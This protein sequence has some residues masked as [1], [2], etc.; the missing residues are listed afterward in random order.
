M[1][2][3]RQY[4]L[5]TLF[6]VREQAKISAEEIFVAAQNEV[7]TQEKHL[8]EL[9]LELKDK[10]A[11]REAKIFEYANDMALGQ[12]IQKIQ[13]QRHHI[14]S[15][16][17]KEHLLQLDIAKQQKMVDDARDAADRKLRIMLKATQDFKALE[18]L[19]ET[20]AAD[21]KKTIEK[22]EDDAAEDISQSQHFS[23][24]FEQ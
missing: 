9:S 20:W 1:Q 24:R 16:K 6:E 12:T 17:H 3:H 13:N 18:K 19:K 8:R 14:E 23:Q 4:Q 11:F 22:L 2:S 21:L 15:L 7:R 5:Q 10:I